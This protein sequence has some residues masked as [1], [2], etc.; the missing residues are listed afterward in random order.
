MDSLSLVCRKSW[1]NS[2]L[3]AATAAKKAGN[4]TDYC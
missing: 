2:L 4:R 1:L 3:I